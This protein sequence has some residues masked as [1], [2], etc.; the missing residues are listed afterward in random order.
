MHLQ[1]TRNW[2]IAFAIV[3][4]KKKTVSCIRGA[5]N[6]KHFSSYLNGICCES[7]AFLVSQD[8][9][10]E[11]GIVC[12]TKSQYEITGHHAL[13]AHAVGAEKARGYL[14]AV[15]MEGGRS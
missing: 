14:G 8:K 6:F 12:N 10:E 1:K 5:I 2:R 11:I 7:T 4:Q 15:Y 13:S 3:C 9:T